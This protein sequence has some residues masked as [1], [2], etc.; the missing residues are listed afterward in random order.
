[1][2]VIAEMK[3]YKL[4]ILGVSETKWKGNGAK[5]VDDCYVVY[6]GVSDGRAKAG[7]A[8]LMTEDTSR[9]VKSWQC[10]NERIVVVKM[11][12][13]RERLTLVQV[14]APTDGS[15]V[16]EKERFYSD[17]QEVIDKLGRK[18]TLVIM[19]DLNARV[20]K[21]CE[22]W[23][24]VIGRNGERVKND[25]GD[26]L[27]RFCAINDMLVMNSWFQHKDIHKFTWVCPGRDLKSIIDYFVVRRDTRVRVKDVKVVRGADASSDHYLLL[28]KMSM[29]CKVQKAEKKAE[30][31]AIQ[32]DRLKERKVRIKFQ[33][34][35]LE[36]MNERE[37]SREEGIQER[38]VSVE[39]VWLE[40]KEGV[41]GAAVEVCGVRRSKGGRKRTRWW[42]DDV[43]EALKQKKIAYLRWV[44]QKTG[45]TKEA[46]QTAKKNARRVIRQAQNE[47]W[48]ELGESL[49]NDFEKNQR[50]FW[51][52]VKASE[53]SREEP[54]KVRG[55][56]GQVIGDE[57]GIL[58]RWREY[59]A[60]LL[61]RDTHGKLSRW[62]SISQGVRQ[63]C[64][65]SPWLFNIYI[66]GIIREAMDELI[67]G[68]QLSNVK[69]Q[70][71]LFADDIVMVT[72]SKE[73]IQ[74]NLEVLKAAMEKW[75]M[76]MHL[77]KTKVMVVS[78]AGEG[79]SVTIDGEKIE[80]VQS[81]KYLGSSISA[82]GSSDEDIEQRIGAATR[83]IGAMRKEV[84]E[85]R[86]LK[87]ET[88]LRVFNAM[89]VPTLL[90][91]C[92][93]WTV[94][95]RHESRLQA[96]EM[97]CLRRIEGVSRIDRV[98]NEDIRDSLGQVAVVDMMKGRQLRWR[99]KLEGMDDD[100][101]VK[102]VYEGDI[103]GRRPR[104]RPRKRWKDN[105]Q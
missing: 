44:Q 46:Y 85:R 49:Q 65:M 38:G 57:D 28:M 103:V 6:S 3:K 14:Y 94:Q 63:G 13:G 16:E 83:V 25:S 82:D 24:N 87:K 45:E 47:E 29:R 18:E 97:G 54:D 48:V 71:L 56:D 68:V 4:D 73:D 40:F 43:K 11:K 51:K 17:L 89:V 19:G 37:L 32:I 61:Q 93:T 76:K 75:D 96:C 91:G 26:R 55:A 67:G 62:F 1:M 5:N 27:L 84:L 60:G 102:Q 35:L 81:L 69:V 52:R 80:E 42:N 36:K 41:I 88:K 50:R 31:V 104:G 92:E 78:R 2:E 98:R 34:K 8:V 70:V 77:G 95:K 101:L 10:V 90:Y 86:E 22:A 39:D 9:F 7:V 58:E 53:R 100:R 64:V 23:G 99:E 72:E 21:D 12:V 74:R 30:N 59:F 15:K 66:D 79:C 105:F 33:A 20:G